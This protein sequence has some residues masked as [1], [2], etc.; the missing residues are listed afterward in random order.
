MHNDPNDGRHH[1]LP[2]PVRVG[3]LLGVLVLA[4]LVLPQ[5]AYADTITVDD[6][7]DLYEA[8]EN[9]NNGDQTNL[10]CAAGSAGHD[11]IAFDLVF[12]ATIR[13]TSGQLEISSDL[14]MDGPGL[15]DL[16][17][18]GN[19]ASR[20]IS[21]TG[22]VTITGVTIADGDVFGFGGGI[23]NQGTLL[24]TDCA[25]SDNTV[26]G[27]GNSGGGIH[28]QEGIVTI[29]NC[30]IADNTV[31]IGADDGGGVHTFS[32]TLTIDNSY[33][34]NNTTAD[35]GGGV[36]GNYATTI[37]IRNTTIFSNTAY[38]NGGGFRLFNPA[39]SAVIE[40]ST[41]SGNRAVGTQGGGIYV[42]NA[43]ITVTNSTISDNRAFSGGGG[44]YHDAASPGVFNLE[45]SIVA[46]N[47]ADTTPFGGPDAGGTINSLDYNLIQDTSGANIVGAVGNNI[48][49]QDPLLGPL[50]DNGGDTTTYALL[51]GSPAVNHIPAGTNGCGTTITADQRGVA[52][53]QGAACDMGSYEAQAVLTLVK[54]VDDATPEP[55]QRIT[56]TIS[57]ENTGAL[58]ATDAVVSDTLSAGLAFAGPVTLDGTAGSVAQD[59]GD[60]PM[61]AS[62]MSVAGGGRITVTFPVTVEVGQAG[63]TEITNVAAVTSVEVVTPESD[64]VSVT[65]E[66]VAPVAEDDADSVL[67]AS[68]DN[69]IDVLDND[70]DLNGDTLSI[71]VVGIP[72]HGGAATED[73]GMIDYSP[74]TGFIGTETF[75]YTVSDGAL[76]D[77]ATVMIEVVAAPALGVTKTVEG[78]NGGTTSLQP[79]SVVTYTI[80]VANNGSEVATGVVMTDEIPLGVTFGGWV[81]QDTAQLTPSGDTIVWGP[82]D[83][84]AHTDYELSFTATITSSEVYAGAVITNTARYVST[85]AGAGSDEAGFSVLSGKLYLPIIFTLLLP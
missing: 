29:E 1:V 16:T 64:Q 85:N 66:N 35:A 59:E 82:Q 43:V 42:R 75:T 20:V 61:L 5:V 52:R 27:A 13:L 77:T 36:R 62:G 68:D 18:S 74:A 10:D 84:A 80:I 8:V 79:G 78:S 3:I 51:A 67:E 70:Y 73:G 30:T 4:L 71:T 6:S 48:T 32:G 44:I 33:I 54:A 7:C 12:P 11:T 2:T 15:S 49:G 55:G 34:Y 69:A 24:L 45:N 17:I 9:A 57:V 56:F 31:V 81:S 39:S 26:R 63:G 58:A 40:N 25:V 22:A 38:G 76:T 21:T 19:D 14:T 37:T 53:P 65:V 47:T 83:V 50:A 60:L 72:D 41:I 23:Y 28:N 46:G